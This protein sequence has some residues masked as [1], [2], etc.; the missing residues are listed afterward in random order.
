MK[1]SSKDFREFMMMLEKENE[2]VHVKR[3]VNAEYEI[4]ASLLQNWTANKQYSLR[5][6]EIARL[7]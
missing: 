3:E 5:M 4:A 1:K 7:E 6:W 2:L